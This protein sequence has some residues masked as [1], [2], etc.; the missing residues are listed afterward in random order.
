[1]IPGEIEALSFRIIEQEAGKHGFSDQE[2]Q[3]VRR[4]IH[5]SADFEYL[6]SIRL[7]PDAIDVGKKAIQKGKT[8]FTDTNMVKA[9]IRSDLMNQFG[10]EV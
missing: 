5:T 4:M 2:W 1:M 9:G 7:H 6:K 3:I 10:V 8:I